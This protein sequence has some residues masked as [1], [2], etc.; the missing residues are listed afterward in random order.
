MKSTCSQILQYILEEHQI[1]V[2]IVFN[3]LAFSIHPISLGEVVEV[4][5]INLK[6]SNFNPWDQLRDLLSI[7]E[8]Y[9]SLVTLM[10]LTQR[11]MEWVE[12]ELALDNSSKE[13]QLTTLL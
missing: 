6:Y 1:E 5:T 12:A 3:I 2:Q 4:V 7:L 10:P 11:E 8:I 9:F 13:H